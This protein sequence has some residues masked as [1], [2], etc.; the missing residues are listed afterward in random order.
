VIFTNT[1]KAMIL[2]TSGTCEFDP[3][4]PECTLWFHSL[5]QISPQ[6]QDGILNNKYSLSISTRLAPFSDLE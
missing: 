3:A 1:G 6:G 2:V 5:S 4:I